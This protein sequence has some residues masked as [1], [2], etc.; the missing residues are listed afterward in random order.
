MKGNI[1]IWRGWMIGY[2]WHTFITAG[3]MCG[4]SE[5]EEWFRFGNWSA[6]IGMGMAYWHLGKGELLFKVQ[7]YEN[8]CVKRWNGG[9]GLIIIGRR[10]ICV[11]EREGH[12]DCANS[13]QLTYFWLFCLWPICLQSQRIFWWSSPIAI[14]K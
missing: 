6:D 12:E 7:V 14:C 1:V 3:N 8:E 9:R 2:E 10:A 5:L 4:G 11:S 13:P